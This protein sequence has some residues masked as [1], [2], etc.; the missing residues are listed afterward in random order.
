MGYCYIGETFPGTKRYLNQER[1]GF[2]DIILFD[3]LK[4]N[5]VNSLQSAYSIIPQTPLK[6][7]CKFLSNLK[8]LFPNLFIIHSIYRW[9]MVIL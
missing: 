2:N 3:K 5:E 4:T 8:K 7:M 6:V 1:N 9:Y